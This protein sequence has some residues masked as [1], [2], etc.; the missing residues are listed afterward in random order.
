MVDYDAFGPEKIIEVYNP[1]VGMHGFLVIDSTA[2]GPGKGGIRMTPSVDKDEVARLA[3]AMTWKCA[4]AEIPF[5]GAK[6]GVIADPKSMTKEKKYEIIKAFSQALK[7]VCPDLYVAAPDINTAEKE[8]EIFAKANGS[9]LSCTGKPKSMGGIPHELGSTGYGVYHATEIAARYKKINLKG[10]TVAVEGFGNVG[11]F[12]AKYLSDAG[13]KLV[14]VSD[15]GGVAYLEKGLDFEQLDSVKKKKGSVVNYFGCTKLS[16]SE[17]LKVKADIL[18]TAAIPDLINVHDVDALKFKII[19]EGS[20]IP[21]TSE[22]EELVHKKGI[23]VVPDFVANAGG[24]I[25][26]YVEFI[27]GTPQKMFKMVKE[28][29]R[30]NTELVLRESFKRK[31]KPRDVAM[32]IAK[33]RV[34]KKCKVCSV[35]N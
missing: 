5:G 16:S 15:S 7:N 12:A 6:S 13:A 18:V 23:L 20:N 19:V 1:K 32:E 27:G 25:S 8:M 24:V 21:M 26:S 9:K 34:L 30:K 35:Q 22:V 2:L 3:R 17:I 28:K 4:L 14:A 33:K 10:A 11:W 31:C 29:V